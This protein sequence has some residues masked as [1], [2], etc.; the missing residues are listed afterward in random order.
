MLRSLSEIEGYTFLAT[1]GEIGKTKD[2][3]FDDGHW[4]VRYAVAD[5]GKWLPGRKVLLSPIFFDEPD[6]RNQRVPVALNKEMIENSPELHEHAPVSRQVE[7]D[8]HAYYTAA[9]YWAG[10][11][12]W[13]GYTSLDAL[14]NAAFKMEPARSPDD[15]SS[16]LR[17]LREVS[18][19]S[20]AAH[21]GEIGHVKDF[22]V[23]TKTW[24]IRWLVI[25]TGSWI[26]GR[27]VLV[28]PTWADSVSWSDRTLK[29][30]MTKKEIENSPEYDPSAPVNAK[31]E[32]HLYDY[33]GRRLQRI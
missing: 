28:S 14:R 9:P 7:R 21:D 25:D 20:I 6:W 4:T 5:T 12:P 32:S 27:N 1:D 19:Y 17:S 13:G 11:G 33:Y 24:T 22:I 3:L 2:F 16:H 29:V 8:F 10:T 23:D 30:T 31:Y 18:G 15:A 26:P